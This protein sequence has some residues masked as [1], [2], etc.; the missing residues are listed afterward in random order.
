MP[1]ASEPHGRNTSEH[2]LR[3]TTRVHVGSFLRGHGGQT[4]R[5]HAGLFLRGHGGAALGRDGIGAR[6]IV[7]ARSRGSALGQESLGRRGSRVIDRSRLMVDLFG[8]EAGK[9]PRRT[10]RSGG[11][12]PRRSARDVT[13]KELK[14]RQ[15]TRSPLS[16]P[17]SHARAH[18]R[19]HARAHARAHA[20]S[21]P[22][23]QAAVAESSGLPS[24]FELRAGAISTLDTWRASASRTRNSWPSATK[25]AP[26]RGTRPRRSTTKPPREW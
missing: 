4:T 26:G 8:A 10:P 17:L 16:R 3:P 7:L 1:L 6:G 20:R 9:F 14:R 24:G 18:A 11:P 25:R 13:A 23:A 21:R 22:Y 12:D 15:H 19:S 2:G 5:V